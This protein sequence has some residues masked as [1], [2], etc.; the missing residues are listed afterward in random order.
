[1]VSAPFSHERP[2]VNE[3]VQP[4]PDDYTELL[5]QRLIN[6]ETEKLNRP[7]ELYR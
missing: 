1:M 4:V 2:V 6:A 5:V 3:K 7:N